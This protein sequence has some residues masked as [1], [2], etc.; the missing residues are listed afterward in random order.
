MPE[1]KIAR[2]KAR[3]KE[4]LQARK[5]ARLQERKLASVSLTGLSDQV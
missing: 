4:I 2:K 3:K 5:I 1:S